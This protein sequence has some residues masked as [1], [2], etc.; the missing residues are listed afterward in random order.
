MK[1]AR[2]PL[3]AALGLTLIGVILVSAR[4]GDG[5]WADEPPL[6]IPLLVPDT[7]VVDPKGVARVV[8]QPEFRS[9]PALHKALVDLT[10]PKL[11]VHLV[12]P[13]VPLPAPKLGARLPA[14]VLSRLLLVGPEEA[15]RRGLSILRRLDRPT[16]SVRICMTIAE[17]WGSKFTERGG[18]LL[19]DRVNAPDQTNTMFR[20]LRI[21]FQPT[22]FV[23]S[24]IM[25][26]RP[27]EG[28]FARLFSEDLYDNLFEATLRGLFRRG[29]ASYVARPTL[30]LNEGETGRLESLRQ[31]PNFLV[32][33]RP[34]EP[35]VTQRTEEVGVKLRVLPVRVGT[36][37]V[38]LDL[39][40]WFRIP[41]AVKDAGAP[42]GALVLKERR[43]RTQ[44]VCR[45]GQPMLIS[46]LRIRRN[47]L[48]RMDPIPF[49]PPIDPIF[50]S[51]ERAGAASEI[52]F[53]IRVYVREPSIDPAGRTHH[54]RFNVR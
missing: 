8:V 27:Y 38:H 25:K 31:L 19:F 9:A 3:A 49:L 34:D 1:P 39:D 43:V 45:D 21:G 52:W 18:S 54:A 32:S 15:V 40:V 24:D 33:G 5:V 36:D 48:G 4:A 20:S 30:T 26:L 50:A 37:A 46:G 17:V 53:V 7:I 42:T 28:N 10:V 47:D 41:D 11:A 13:R 14:P 2:T 35:V 12:S 23:R 29:H 22:E 51:E 6:L 16:R 44:V